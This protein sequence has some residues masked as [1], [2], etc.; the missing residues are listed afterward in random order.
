[1]AEAESA[2]EHAD[3]VI[4]LQEAF[5]DLIASEDVDVLPREGE[6][7]NDI[8]VAGEQWT[9]YLEGWPGPEVAFIAVEDEPEED[10]APAEVEQ[11]WRAAI[12]ESALAALADADRRLGG[13]LRSLLIATGD[14]VSV[15]V[16]ENLPA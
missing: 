11:T 4:A 15:S 3:V 7:G 13:V 5:A 10:A 8:A 2:L 14:P 9:L 16:A 6:S 1:M 12:P